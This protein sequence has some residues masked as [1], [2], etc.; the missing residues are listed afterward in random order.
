MPQELDEALDVGLDAIWA[1]VSSLADAL[2]ARLAAVPGA[3][4]RDLGTVVCGIV[5]FDIQGVPAAEIAARL[6]ER[7][8]NEYVSTPEDTRL[9]FE[10]RGLDP[11]VRASVHYFDTEAEVDAFA[12]AVANLA[13]RGVAA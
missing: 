13:R 8:I 9:D 4:V 7:A 2:R 3:T 10:S 1:R 12:D 5:T 6:G 11:L